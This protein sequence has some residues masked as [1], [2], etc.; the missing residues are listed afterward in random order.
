[1]VGSAQGQSAVTGH[2]GF[3]TRGKQLM[4]YSTGRTD[5]EKV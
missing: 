4:L 3:T 5:F 1:M 2:V